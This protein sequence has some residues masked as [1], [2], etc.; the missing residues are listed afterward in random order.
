[1][2]AWWPLLAS[3]LLLFSH[4]ASAQ[5]PALQGAITAQ[6][7][8][9]AV[10]TDADLERRLNRKLMQIARDFWISAK[11]DGLKFENVVDNIGLRN[12]AMAE[13]GL[14]LQVIRRETS[15]EFAVT[16][17]VG[18]TAPRAWVSLSDTSPDSGIDLTAIDGALMT[19]DAVE[20]S[21]GIA[22]ACRYRVVFANNG[23]HDERGHDDYARAYSCIDFLTGQL[24][25]VVIEDLKRWAADLVRRSAQ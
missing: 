24:D 8:R 9:E 18:E 11:A 15:N 3:A 25:A 16:A 10:R 1:M 6:Q 21:G 23:E 5:D 20:P 7:L 22:L 12:A 14:P 19:H 4:G 17:R 2:R 13:F